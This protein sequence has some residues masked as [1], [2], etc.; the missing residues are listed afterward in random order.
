MRMV[1][2]MRVMRMVMM[3]KPKLNVELPRVRRA[4]LRLVPKHN[5]LA[6][7]IAERARGFELVLLL[8]EELAHRIGFGWVNNIGWKGSPSR[9][10]LMTW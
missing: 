2:V 9:R 10:V 1:R 6:R 4:K 5:A 7:I 3:V 8:C